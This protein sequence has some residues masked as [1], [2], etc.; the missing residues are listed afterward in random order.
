MSGTG[1]RTIHSCINVRGALTNWRDSEWRNCVT[2]KDGKT[3]SPA[4]VKAGF[5]EELANGNE[6]IPFGD[7]DDF[8]PKKGCRGH[9]AVSIGEQLG[10]DPQQAKASGQ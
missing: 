1:S 6:F 7:C 8:D 9:R 5:L 4:E 3:L 2:D 10:R